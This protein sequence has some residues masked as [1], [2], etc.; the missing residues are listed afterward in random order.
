[1][2]ND[3]PTVLDPWQ[4]RQLHHGLKTEGNGRGRR[5]AGTSE[6]KDACAGDP[7]GGPA[8]VIRGLSRELLFETSQVLRGRSHSYRESL[9]IIGFGQDAHPGADLRHDPLRRERNM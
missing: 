1:M 5:N 2:R 6:A 3:P 4:Q 7:D 8:G 9:G